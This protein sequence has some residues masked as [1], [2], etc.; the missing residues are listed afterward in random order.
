MGLIKNWIVKRRLKQIE[1]IQRE[2]ERLADA[3]VKHVPAKETRLRAAIIDP[4]TKKL[5]LPFK[6]QFVKADSSLFL[7]F[8]VFLITVALIGSTAFY[9]VKISKMNT[10][11]TASVVEVEK[12]K[13]ELLAKE[14]NLSVVQQ[15]LSIKELREEELEDVFSEERSDLKN[16]IKILK[17]EKADL[18]ADVVSLE[19]KIKKLETENAALKKRVGELENA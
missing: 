16:E 5:Q 3:K 10:D 14:S 17:S 11:F 19:S 12:L 7:L 8:T 15:T 2:I 13:Q 1:E 6:N 4:E 18:E 9:Q